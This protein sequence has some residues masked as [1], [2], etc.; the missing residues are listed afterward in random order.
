MWLGESQHPQRSPEEEASLLLLIMTLQMPISMANKIWEGKINL[1][2]LWLVHR[3]TPQ[4]LGWCFFK[5]SH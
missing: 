4:V 2:T 3:N 1:G 5:R